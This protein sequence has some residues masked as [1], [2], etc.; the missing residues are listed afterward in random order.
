MK[1]RHRQT[2][3]RNSQYLADYSREK[4][5]ANENEKYNDTFESSNNTC[6]NKLKEEKSKDCADEDAASEEEI[7]KTEEDFVK[8]SVMM[9][10]RN[11]VLLEHIRA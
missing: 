1:T 11:V 7:M 2:T 10:L 5:E 6:S 4:V 8:E 3:L 9:C